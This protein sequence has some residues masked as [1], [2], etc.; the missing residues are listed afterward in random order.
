VITEPGFLRVIAAET[1]SRRRGTGFADSSAAEAEL[2]LS[3]IRKIR[4][5][6]FET[7]Y[8]ADTTT[9]DRLVN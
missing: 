1:L 6:L 9:P 3:R 5:S 7:I 8:F 2:D 4:A